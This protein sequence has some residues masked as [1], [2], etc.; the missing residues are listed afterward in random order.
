MC[1]FLGTS[2]LCYII[3]PP[4][5]GGVTPRLF[6]QSLGAFANFEVTSIILID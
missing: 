4:Q 2:S 6:Q 1:L 5:N 3:P